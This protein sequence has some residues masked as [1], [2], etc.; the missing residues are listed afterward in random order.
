MLKQQ[1]IRRYA[2]WYHSQFINR[3]IN[4]IKL[5]I[6]QVKIWGCILLNW[7]FNPVAKDIKNDV[8]L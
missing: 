5:D 4:P 2:T 1:K 3:P 7:E 8:F 6:S